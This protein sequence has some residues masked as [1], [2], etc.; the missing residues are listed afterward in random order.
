M[1]AEQVARVKYAY[2]A[3][4]QDGNG[5]DSREL[6]SFMQ[7]VL[8]RVPSEEEV[9]QGL[10]QMDADGSGTISF[11]EMMVALNGHLGPSAAA[12]AGTPATPAPARRCASTCHWLCTR[13]GSLGRPG[14]PAAKWRSARALSH[15]LTPVGRRRRN[16]VA[17]RCAAGLAAWAS[18][19]TS[20][21]YSVAAWA[22]DHTSKNIG[23]V[24][25]CGRSSEPSRENGARAAAAAIAAA[26]WQSGAFAP[27]R[28]NIRAP[29]CDRHE[30]RRSHLAARAGRH[31]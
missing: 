20:G 2:G 18:T 7:V 25:F 22:H 23:C 30:R 26:S 19:A 28:T 14:W 17:T 24:T 29:R 1:T 5:L 6:S 12:S 11:D 3:F 15:P 16:S 27:P 10:A 9:M 13:P 31:C 21:Q 4:D 8:G